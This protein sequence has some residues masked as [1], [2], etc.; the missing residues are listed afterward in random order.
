LNSPSGSSNVKEPR[1]SGWGKILK[2][3]GLAWWKV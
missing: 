1:Y 3:P 2:L